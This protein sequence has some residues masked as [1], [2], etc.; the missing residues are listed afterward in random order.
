MQQPSQRPILCATDFS[1][2]AAKAA[3]VAAAMAKRLGTPL[4]LAHGIDE[5]GEIPASYWPSLEVALRE[6]LHAEAGRVRRAGIE[7]EE[8][9]AGGAPDDGVAS[10]AERADARCIVLGSNN[11]G[12]LGRMVLGSVSES[13]AE[14]AWVPTLVLKES[15]R[16]EDWA[17]GGK[18]LRVFIGADFTSNSDAALTWAA[19]LREI[20]PCEFTIG[21]V[22]LLADRRA[23]ELKHAPART[24]SAEEM[25]EMLLRDLRER[26]NSF[27]QKDAIHVRVLPTKGRVDSHLLEMAA[28]A[29]ADLI[30][31]GTHQWQGIRR[32]RHPSVSRR[33]LHTAQTNV[34][35][36]PSRRAVS[37]HST[38][39]SQA[40]RILV[41]TGLSTHDGSAVP[42]AFSMLQ[43]GGTAWLLHVAPPSEIAALQTD[44][45]RDMIP[46]EAVEQGFKVQAEVISDHDVAKA[47]CETADRLDVD[48]ICLGSRGPCKRTAALG[49]TTLAVLARSTRPVLIVPQ[50][51]P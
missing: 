5:H 10:R 48:L 38:C 36:V 49:D 46:A 45:L 40:H 39:I 20:G 29:G 21:F 27:F 28:E 2:S 47:I 42:Y 35:C 19:G 31:I 51:S 34:A 23:D 44:R 50:K 6:Q 17:R 3:D 11:H 30:V 24:P 16:I 37:T 8:I 12:T 43:P 4:L 9:I 26:A 14:S 32:L 13:I 41:A 1:E 25:H 15:A 18:P 7:V 33:I 22:D